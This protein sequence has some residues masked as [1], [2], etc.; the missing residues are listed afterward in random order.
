MKSDLSRKVHVDELEIG[1]ASIIIESCLLQGTIDQIRIHNYAT[2]SL[3]T[4]SY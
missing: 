1:F 2:L 4:S 3:I